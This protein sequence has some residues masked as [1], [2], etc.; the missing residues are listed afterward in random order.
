MLGRNVK[1]ED[2]FQF[3]E[4][5]F[6][7]KEENRLKLPEDIVPFEEVQP[8]DQI[9]LWII[10]GLELMVFLGAV[11]LAGAPLISLLFG[12]IMIVITM[13]F[14]SKLQL[15]SRIDSTGVNYRMSFLH[16]KEQVIPWEDIDQ[17][18]VR[19]YSPIREYGGWGIRFG[20]S[21][22]AFNVRGNYGIQ[23]VKKDG[24]RVLIGTQAPD[25]A[26]MHLS[27]HPLLV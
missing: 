15:T 14:M 22:K 19:K 10:L 27:Q 13:A 23:V 21:G 5:V 1:E 3:D 4:S 2:R 20:P 17:I 18:Y 16:R 6:K 7:P 26:A 8:F 24:K 9:W 25:A 12:G 11:L